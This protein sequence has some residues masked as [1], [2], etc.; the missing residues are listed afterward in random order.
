ML[1]SK[2]LFYV[3]YYSKSTKYLDG[4]NICAFG[5]GVYIASG[6]VQY[7]TYNGNDFE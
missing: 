1:G 4:V 2:S 5:F 3:I 6:D 7:G